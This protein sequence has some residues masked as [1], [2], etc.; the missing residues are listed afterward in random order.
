MSEEWTWKKVLM[1]YDQMN[2]LSQAKPDLKLD[3]Y[4]LT[5]VYNLLEFGRI[6]EAEAIFD[7]IPEE[8]FASEI[9]LD[10]DESFNEA[11][12]AI[13][14]KNQLQSKDLFLPK[15][16]EL[17]HKLTD[18]QQRAEIFI[19]ITGFAEAAKQS[20]TISASRRLEL[21]RNTIS[22]KSYTLNLKE[23]LNRVDH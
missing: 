2:K 10:L 21:L 23:G 14:L 3:K 15:R 5:F 16:M 6:T 20:N 8:Y 17:E 13:S 22:G 1:M 12:L 19:V 11:Q 9:E 4:Y 7:E 18:A